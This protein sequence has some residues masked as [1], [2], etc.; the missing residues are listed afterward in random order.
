M[1]M[2]PF[3]GTALLSLYS[4][5]AF[6]PLQTFLASPVLSPFFP[7]LPT[8]FLLTP[9]PCALLPFLDTPHALCALRPFPP[10]TS[11]VTAAAPLP[12]PVDRSSQ[13][14]SGLNLH[15]LFHLNSLL[16]KPS[17][18]RSSSSVTYGPVNIQCSSTNPIHIVSPASEDA[19]QEY[20]IIMVTNEAV[21]MR[22][23]RSSGSIV[24]KVAKPFLTVVARSEVRECSVDPLLPS[25]P[26]NN[27]H[28]DK[29]QVYNLS[30]HASRVSTSLPYLRVVNKNSTTCDRAT[31]ILADITARG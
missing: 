29:D 21:C 16:S 3:T 19:P 24:H 6:I 4:L 17:S 12:S 10:M 8:P 2:G 18:S 27:G 5:L 15:R 9:C 11:F 30:C 25:P 31:A 23:T 28:P 7:S 20:N 14:S 1:Y 13:L 26:A 22:P